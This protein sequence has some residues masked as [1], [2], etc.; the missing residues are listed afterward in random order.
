MAVM[1][2][3]IRIQS[4]PNIIFFLA[5]DMGWVDSDVY[6]SDF[7]ETPALRRLASEGMMF[8][9]A[10]AQ[11]LC[12]PTRAAVMTGKYPCARLGMHSAITPRGVANPVVPESGAPN[13]KMVY[14]E[15]RDRLPLEE[16]TIAEALKKL[17]YQT[18]HLGKWHLHP[19][20]P[21]K[22]GCLLSGGSRF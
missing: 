15:L 14:P 3:R 6:G 1:Q 16:S 13:S 4:K 11:P 2:S 5:D 10:Y 7:Y 12:S 9:Q 17:G 18:W 20:I 21:R 19:G 22:L 8:T